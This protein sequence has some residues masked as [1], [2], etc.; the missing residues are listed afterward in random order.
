EPE[1]RPSSLRVRGHR[2]VHP[3]IGKFVTPIVWSGYEAKVVC[4]CVREPQQRKMPQTASIPRCNRQNRSCREK[5]GCKTNGR[6]QSFQPKILREAARY[7]CHERDEK[8]REIDQ[9]VRPKSEPHPDDR[10]V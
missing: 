2:T 9:K 7:K 10:A 5:E 1:V 6:L 3:S 8:R 4:E